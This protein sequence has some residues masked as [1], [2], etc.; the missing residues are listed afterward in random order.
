[1]YKNII[2]ISFLVIVCFSRTYP[3]YKQCDPQ[4]KD[5]PLGFS[6]IKTICRDGSLLT[7]VSM[8]LKGAGNKI[9]TPGTLDLWLREHN[10][11]TDVDHYVWHSIDNIGMSFVGFVNK[12]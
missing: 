8:G 11:W 12:S 7:C 3:L 2:L 4:W 9:S 6:K 1:M 5:S 10:G